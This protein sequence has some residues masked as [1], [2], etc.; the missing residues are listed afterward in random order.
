M[1]RRRA[2]GTISLGAA[3]LCLLLLSLP[4]PVAE[5]EGK[6]LVQ[7]VRARV[8]TEINDADQPPDHSPGRIEME[9]RRTASVWV[10]IPINQ[11][12]WRKRMQELG[13]SPQAPRRITAGKRDHL[14]KLIVG[15]KV[16][17][18]YPVGFGRNYLSDKLE[19]GDRTSPEG[20]FKITYKFPSKKSHRS[21][22]LNYPNEDTRRKRARARKLG[23]KITR[24][25]GSDIC[26]HGHGVCG[27]KTF[28][29]KDGVYYVKNWTRGCLTVNDDLMEEVYEFAKPGMTVEIVW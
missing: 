22:C 17:G 16:V 4:A 29:K 23:V 15:G 3:A 28:F 9:G 5:A 11:P 10:D 2:I 18:T 13:I 6:A 8:I 20:V 7:T 27:G 26:L 25:A 1:K 24:D 14:L 12:H 19:Q 21:L